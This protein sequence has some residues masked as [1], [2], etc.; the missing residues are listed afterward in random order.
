M[1]N[2]KR[3]EGKT[4][5]SGAGGAGGAGG[6]RGLEEAGKGSWDRRG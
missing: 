1:G 6:R 4:L 2:V 5:G 3:L